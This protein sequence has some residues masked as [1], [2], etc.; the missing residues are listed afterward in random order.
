[1]RFLYVFSAILGITNA[2]LFE[3]YQKTQFIRDWAAHCADRY[4]PSYE[5]KEISPEIRKCDTERCV[6]YM[7]KYISDHCP[8]SYTNFD[9]CFE[10][11]TSRKK[12]RNPILL[13]SQSTQNYNS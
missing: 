13:R 2:A 11:N 12:T 6:F 3:D 8:E 7:Y 10:T 9:I 1:M 5:A 4:L